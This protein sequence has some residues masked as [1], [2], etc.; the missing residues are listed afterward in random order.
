MHVLCIRHRSQSNGSRAGRCVFQ[1]LPRRR[2]RGQGT[3]SEPS[4]DEL[5]EQDFE[6]T[7][8]GR[9]SEKNGNEFGT[10]VNPPLTWQPA[11]AAS[12]GKK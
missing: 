9:K 10:W 3:P 8:R 1:L 6:I 12:H 11:G 7:D 5:C 2:C 4:T